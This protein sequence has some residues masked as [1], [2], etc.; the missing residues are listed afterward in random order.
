MSMKHVLTTCLCVGAISA[1]ALPAT[2]AE[3]IKAWKGEAARGV[4][5]EHLYMPLTEE[6][7]YSDRYTVEAWFEDGT[8]VWVSFLV[9][10]F[11]PGTHKMKVRARFHEKGGKEH[12]VSDTVERKEY[13][14]KNEKPFHVSAKAQTLSGT[15]SN[16]KVKG[17]SGAYS[18][19]LSFKSGLRPFRPGTGRTEFGDGSLYFDHTLVQ[20][21]AEVSG[22]V[23]GK[24]I[25]GYGYVIHT[26]GNIA[27]FSMFKNYLQVRSID[28]DTVVWFHEFTTPAKYGGKRVGYLY[29]ARDGKKLVGTTWY[30]RKFAD[31]KPD[32]AH[33]NK[34][35]VPMK[36]LVQGKRKATKLQV[37]VAA[38]KI[39]GRV[40]ELKS[41]G[42]FEAAL[43]KQYAQPVNYT[44]SAKVQVV[45]QE[46]EAEA[47]ESVSDAAYEISHLN[48]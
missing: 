10:N 25:K 13:T 9:N 36:I 18:W 29:V 34:Y 6:E 40:D 47:V 12:Y 45:V 8:R 35:K 48:R 39:I 11:G 19:N 3:P 28:S 32:T 20:P 41:R 44:M 23:N 42:A 7:Y 27:P 4:K 16:I 14:V 1:L 38:D 31:M 43:I 2:A 46:G 21:K 17:K 24:A 22:T 26:H 15:P 30:K 5:T 33:A 37:K